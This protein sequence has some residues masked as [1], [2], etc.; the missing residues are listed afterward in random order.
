MYEEC[1]TILNKRKQ[2]LDP[3]HRGP[4][5]GLRNLHDGAGPVGYGNGRWHNG[6]VAHAF[7][8]TRVKSTCPMRLKLKCEETVSSF[9]FIFHLRRYITAGGDAS[10]SFGL[11]TRAQGTAATAGP[12]GF[13]S[14]R[15]Q[16][17]FTSRDDMSGNGP[18][19]YSR[20]VFG[21]RFNDIMM[22]QKAFQ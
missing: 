9:A 15:R 14:P 8:E 19:G 22:V 13:C 11:L 2:M 18:G 20:Y 17:S 21:S 10:T 5:D 4:R 16:M 7:I 6:G 1:S 3:R 12:G